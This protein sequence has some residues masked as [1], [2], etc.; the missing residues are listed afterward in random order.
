[1]A[2]VG[3]PPVSG[4]LSRPQSILSVLQTYVQNGVPEWPCVTQASLGGCSSWL[5]GEHLPPVLS[6]ITDYRQA[7]FILRKSWLDSS[8][9]EKLENLT[10]PLCDVLSP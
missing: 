2:V 4:G 5:F 3:S 1:M 7:A 10:W 6:F 8:P 9:A